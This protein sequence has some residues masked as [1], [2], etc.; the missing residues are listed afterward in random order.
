MLVP[1][2]AATLLA[3]VGPL[4]SR[5][6]SQVE[7]VPVRPPLER[8]E[9]PAGEGEI[10]WNLVGSSRDETS[11]LDQDPVFQIH[12]LLAHWSDAW[13]K[14]RVDEYLSFYSERFVPVDGSSRSE[15]AALRRERLLRPSFIR[16]MI[17]EV[18][19]DLED[20]QSAQVQFRQAYEADRYRDE[21][22]KTLVVVRE[23][24]QWKILR[25]SSVGVD[26]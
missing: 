17:S 16:I 5:A 4:S 19:I 10:Q 3:W 21:V 15:W 14:K 20:G 1:A 25:E 7:L 26:N 23:G 11:V 2:L 6:A 22:L 9:R 24:S 13:A 8:A 18:R 12:R